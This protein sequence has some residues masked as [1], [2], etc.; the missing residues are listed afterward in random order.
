MTHIIEVLT[1][2]RRGRSFSGGS[3]WLASILKLVVILSEPF[4]C[5]QARLRELKDL[6][7][8]PGAE[9]ISTGQCNS[10]TTLR[11]PPCLWF[12]VALALRA[13]VASRQSSGAGWKRHNKAA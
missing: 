5:A 3:N 10:D 1:F 11:R 9:V 2:S 8:P 12:V 4:D 6:H 13:L 7:L